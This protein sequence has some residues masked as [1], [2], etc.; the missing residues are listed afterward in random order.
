VNAII[1]HLVEEHG[2]DQSDAESR[3]AGWEIIPIV[4][5][6]TEVGHLAKQGSEIH[7]VL[8]PEY[9]NTAKNRAVIRLYHAL[10]KDCVFLTTRI[11]LDDTADIPVTEGVGFREVRRDDQF[12][13]YWMDQSTVIG[14]RKHA[15]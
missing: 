2:L 11:P 12:I 5:G 6:E 4:S 13:Y 1:R 15:P 14:G 10:L 9:R 3:M 8:F 7:T